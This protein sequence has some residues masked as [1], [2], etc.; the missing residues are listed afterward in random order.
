MSSNN[1]PI[2]SGLTNVGTHN[3]PKA[4]RSWRCSFHFRTIRAWQVGENEFLCCLAR[5]VISKMFGIDVRFWW[6]TM[7]F[8]RQYEEFWGRRGVPPGKEE[9]LMWSAGWAGGVLMVMEE[10][11]M[12]VR[13]A[14]PGRGVPTGIEECL[15]SGTAHPGSAAPKGEGGKQSGMT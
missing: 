13:G 3:S 15:C 10:C 5:F 2:W 14:N 4:Q 8:E 9:Y 6:I 1:S 7:E 11:R 12:K